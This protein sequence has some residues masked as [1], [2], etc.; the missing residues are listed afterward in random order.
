MGC[1][2]GCRNYGCVHPPSIEITVATE[3]EAEAAA[4]LPPTPEAIILA[5]YTEA[6]RIQSKA[7]KKIAR[8]YRMAGRAHELTSATR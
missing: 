5:A 4:G 6:N 8:L 2:K 7:D 1:T 3:A